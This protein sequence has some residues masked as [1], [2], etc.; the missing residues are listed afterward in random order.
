MMM[1]IVPVCEDIETWETIVVNHEFEDVNPITV[2]MLGRDFKY[3]YTFIKKQGS[4]NAISI[5]NRFPKMDVERILIDLRDMHL[6]YF[7]RE[8]K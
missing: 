7:S 3:I 1:E 6:V 8:V 5:F 4:V 2:K